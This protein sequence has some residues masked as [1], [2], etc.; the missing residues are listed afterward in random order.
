MPRYRL[1]VNGQQEDIDAEGRVPLALVL[2][3]SLGLTGTR[4]G[5]GLEQCGACRVL[6]DGDLAWSCTRT[7]EDTGGRHVLTIESNDP[8]TTALKQAFLA[9]NAGQCGFCLSGIIVTASVLLRENPAPDR[10]QIQAALRDNLCR[11]GAHNR[12][13][14]AISDA[15][16]TLR[17]STP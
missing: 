3:E 5:C 6:V 2:R 15:A 17:G 9:R 13:I 1:T 16:A 11:C 10:T 12:M 4:Q 8:I 7:L 14:Q